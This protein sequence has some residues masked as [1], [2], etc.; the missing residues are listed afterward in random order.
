MNGEGSFTVLRVG[1]NGISIVLTDV[2][3]EA[4][5]EE[6]RSGDKRSDDILFSLLEE[7]VQDGTIDFIRPEEVGALT[8][9]PIFGTDVVRDDQ[10][11][12]TSYRSLYWFPNYQVI[13]PVE[14]LEEAGEVYF[15][16]EEFEENLHQESRLNEAFVSD[17][18]ASLDWTVTVYQGDEVVSS[19]VIENRTEREA[20]KEA[21]ADIERDFPEY[22]RTLAVDWTLEPVEAVETESGPEDE[23]EP[24]EDD[25]VFDDSERGPGINFYQSGK[26]WLHVRDDED[27]DDIYDKIRRKMERE[28]F[29][30]NLWHIS[31]HGNAHLV[32]DLWKDVKM[33]AKSEKWAQKASE[34]MKKKGTEGSL[35]TAAK[36]AGEVHCDDGRPV[37]DCPESS[38]RVNKSYIN[39]MAKSDNPEMV[40]KAQF[41][42]NVNK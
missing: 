6:M 31:D 17:R 35:T 22:G 29:Y 2:G 19:W 34:K 9:S 39:K 1:K 41:A 40:K 3:R 15:N 33:E 12:V 24:Q 16:G 14:E 20:E 11:N 38:L 42:K 5:E 36:K 8:D 10:G 28:G 30:P 13:D 25:V 32:T 23:D 7:H 4:L 37:K 21:E 27:W 26:P 18:N